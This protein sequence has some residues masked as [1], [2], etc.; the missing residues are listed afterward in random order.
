MSTRALMMCLI[1]PPVAAILTGIVWQRAGWPAPRAAIVGTLIGVG[2]LTLDWPNVIRNPFRLIPLT[3]VS[4][5][6]V[7][8]FILVAPEL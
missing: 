8:L 5:L 4:G 6:V 3:V 7:A 2:G 1:A